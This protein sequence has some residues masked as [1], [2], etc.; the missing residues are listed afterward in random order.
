V[1]RDGGEAVGYTETPT[2]FSHVAITYHR[3]FEY[4]MM[5]HEL[6]LRRDYCATNSVINN[7]NYHLL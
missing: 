1:V 2:T 3:V 5:G 6:Q 7:T 4:L